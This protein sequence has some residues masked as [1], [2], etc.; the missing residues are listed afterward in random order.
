M[1]RLRLR[2]SDASMVSVFRSEPLAPCPDPFNMAQYVLAQAGTSSSKVALSVLGACPSADV[3][4][5]YDQI[6]VSVQ[7]MARLLTA[8]GLS[9]GDVVMMRIGNTVEFP[10][11]Y[12][13]CIAAGIV[14]VPTSSQLTEAEVSKL[15]GLIDCAAILHSADVPCPDDVRRLDLDLFAD[16]FDRGRLPAPDPDFAYDR[17]DPNR[18]A[19][20]VFTSG[21]SGQARP[22][23]HAHRAIWAR[24]MMHD[25]WYGLRA[26]DRMLHAGAFNWTYTL[27][28]GL[29]DPWSVGAT[30]LIPAQGTEIA[31]LP[32]LLARADA[33]MFAAAPGIFRKLVDSDTPLDLPALRHGL[34][35]GEK[36]PAAVQTAW[37]AATGVP[38]YEAYGQS[39]CSTFIS[40]SPARAVSPEHLGYPQTG[41]HIAIVGAHGPVPFGEIGTIAV[42]RDDPGLM[43]GYAGAPEETAK[44]YQGDWYLTGDQA[45][46][47]EDGAITYLGRDDDMMN[48]GGFRVSPLEVEAALSGFDGIAQV[49]VTD[50]EIKP[51]AFVIAAFYTSDVPLD[52]VALRRYAERHL[53]RYKQPR[54][55]KRLDALPL[56][57]N[58]KLLRRALKPL[59]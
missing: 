21:T 22:V 57:G 46:M 25:G 30:A 48:A 9:A 31:A 47:T 49:G 36:L 51:G 17:G 27:G 2:G 1:Q 13:A 8:R 38:L 16:A 59:K 32:A 40:S 12:L 53:A 37:R 33:T 5:R 50:V 58:G 55:F 41:R 6:T 39:E 19:Y 15:L 7:M 42:H 23:M 20:M 28:T 10:I 14:P 43:L 52:E 24:R 29:M 26:A 34:T 54:L 11:A 18:L 56:G 44:R 3:Q 4:W 35:A 45:C